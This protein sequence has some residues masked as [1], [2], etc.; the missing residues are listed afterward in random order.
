[1]LLKYEEEEGTSKVSEFLEQWAE[2]AQNIQDTAQYPN[3]WME[4]RLEFCYKSFGLSYVN[5]D[6]DD[7]D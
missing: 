7:D 4:A 6:D 5:D 1:M 3:L 2:D